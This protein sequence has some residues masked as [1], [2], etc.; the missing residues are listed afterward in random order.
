MKSCIRK[1]NGVDVFFDPDTAKFSAEI[2]GK[3]VFSDSFVAI[4]KRIDKGGVFKSFPIIRAEFGYIVEDRVTGLVKN[5]SRCGGAWLYK[6]TSGRFTANKV[7]ED[8]PENR[9]ALQDYLA[10]RKQHEVQ[11]QAMNEAE[12]KVRAAIRDRCADQEEMVK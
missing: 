10:L 2:A 4:K 7:T 11:K 12:W 3:E 9:K 6:T 1:H 8:T 5:P